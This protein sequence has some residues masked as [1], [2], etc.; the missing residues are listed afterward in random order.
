MD[1]IDCLPQICRR[2]NLHGNVDSADDEHAIFVLNFAAHVCR[3]PAIAR[4][5]FARLQRAS[6][7]SPLLT[8]VPPLSVFLT[9]KSPN[10]FDI[11][12]MC[13]GPFWKNIPNDVLAPRRCDIER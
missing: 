11:T 7:G 9:S 8:S 13:M 3:E 12:E 4:I 6:K 5:N 10:Q 2:L 1:A